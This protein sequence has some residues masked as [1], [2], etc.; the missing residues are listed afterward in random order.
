MKSMAKLALGIPI[1]MVAIGCSE[2]ADTA[3]PPYTI[4]ED[5]VSESRNG[6]GPQSSD[7]GASSTDW[8]DVSDRVITIPESATVTW[9]TVRFANNLDGCSVFG[10]GAQYG[11]K[12][13][14]GNPGTYKIPGTDIDVTLV[15]LGRID[16]VQAYE[17]SIEP[18]YVMTD[19]FLKHR[20]DFNEWFHFEPGVTFA[21][22]VFTAQQGLSHFSVCANDAWLPLEFDH[23][24]EASYDRTV[25]WDL[26]K[27][28]DIPLHEGMPGDTFSSIWTVQATKMAVEE[29]ETVIGSLTVFNPNAV[30]VPVAFAVALNGMA[31]S[32]SCPGAVD[33]NT[34]V[35]PAGGSLICSYSE[36][37][38][39]RLSSQSTAIM[40]PGN[41]LI[42]ADTVVAPFVWTENLSGFESGLLEDP[43]VAFSAS[44][45]ASRTL[46]IPE[47]FICPDDVG[48][49]TDGFLS[50]V[51]TN[52]VTLNGGIN[53]ADTA[54][55]TVV[56]RMAPP[57]PERSESAW[58]ANGN[59][60]GSIRYTPQGNWATYLAYEGMAKSVTLFAGQTIP[61]GTVSLSAP[62][63]GMVTVTITLDPD[64]DFAPGDRIHIQ[65]YA[66]APSGNPAP[67][68]FDFSFE[69]GQAIMVPANHFYG[70]HA[71][72]V[73]PQN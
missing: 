37:P 15:S 11:G 65:D 58:A 59:E 31:P 73:G 22:N 4:G 10:T 35:V 26:T 68:Q 24:V 43:R 47:P 71:V 32:V 21:S 25:E 20:V 61:V 28:V 17:I 1:V 56:C 3:A 66:M 49:Y 33:P 72:V 8:T 34:G 60:P 51:E 18:G 7:F 57:P 42:P 29:N 67:G 36:S 13:D 39:D 44:V 48:S 19:L 30:P 16:G 46:E 45:S 63:G 14:T 64:W 53:L 52:V 40:T 2:R 54:T 12:I 62:V 9:R 23:M 38:A 41:P 50:Y 27:T 6:F 55:V 69:P 70:I 5:A